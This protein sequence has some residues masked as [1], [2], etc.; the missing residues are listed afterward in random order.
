MHA[1]GV[2]CSNPDK[3]C[4]GWI[5]QIITFVCLFSAKS[6][7]FCCCW[8]VALANQPWFNSF[9]SFCHCWMRFFATWPFNWKGLSGR[10]LSAAGQRAL[11]DLHISHYWP[12]LGEVLTVIV[13]SCQ[14]WSGL[15]FYRLLLVTCHP[16][17]PVRYIDI[18]YR[19]S[20]YQHFWKISISIWSFM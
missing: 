15:P 8:E 5:V 11:L 12:Y 1:K 4:L 7:I 19:L 20:I 18:E 6:F 9:A 10:V 2:C 17:S 14:T 3:N 13:L 16:Y